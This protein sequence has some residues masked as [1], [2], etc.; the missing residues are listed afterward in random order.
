MKYFN[1]GNKSITSFG[2]VCKRECKIH[3]LKSFF[4]NFNPTVGIFRLT[5]I[6]F[7]V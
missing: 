4:F 5:I 2:K 1:F 6:N 7:P 3:I